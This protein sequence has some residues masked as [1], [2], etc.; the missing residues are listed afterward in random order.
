TAV[1]AKH[2]PAVTAAVKTIFAHTDPDEVA[3][4]PIPYGNPSG[5]PI[6]SATGGRALTP[7]PPTV[8]TPLTYS[9]TDA[10]RINSTHVQ[11]LRRMTRPRPAHAGARRDDEEDDDEE[12]DARS[13]VVEHAA[14]DER[15]HPRE[16][17]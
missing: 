10:R 16:V 9:R 2:A 5:N 13:G 11:F 15:E 1:A 4:Q 7:L 14:P 12:D 8:V 17:G 3:A 6:C